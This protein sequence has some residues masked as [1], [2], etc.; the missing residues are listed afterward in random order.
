M[1]Q[2]KTKKLSF[3]KSTVANLAGIKGGYYETIDNY[4][5]LPVDY[6]TYQVDVCKTCKPCEA[7]APTQPGA[8]CDSI[9]P[10]NCY[11][12]E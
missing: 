2:L 10:D 6:D 11:L 3:S 4:C 7:L 12:M 8:P 1:K 9:I 5:T